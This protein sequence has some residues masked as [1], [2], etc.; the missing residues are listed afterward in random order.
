MPRVKPRK[1]GS[2]LTKREPERLIQN[3]IA[4]CGPGTMRLKFRLEGLFAISLAALFWLRFSQKTDFTGRISRPLPRE[5]LL[6][7]GHGLDIP[8]VNGDLRSKLGRSKHSKQ[9]IGITLH[10]SFCSKFW[11]PSMGKPL[12]PFFC[13]KV[14]ETHVSGRPLSICLSKVV[15]VEF[16][17][18][19]EI[20]LTSLGFM[21][22]AF[23]EGQTFF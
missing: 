18:P 1:E 21:P 12:R 15:K 7:H 8:H 9:S 3:W 11:N 16:Q 4:R 17:Y 2:P 13:I 14:L 19:S 20:T 22:P 10:V 5:V 6:S 23:W